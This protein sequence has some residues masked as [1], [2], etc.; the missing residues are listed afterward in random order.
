MYPLLYE[1]VNAT[2]LLFMKRFFFLLLLCSFFSC[3]KKENTHSLISSN[4][5]RNVT[6]LIQEVNQL[7]ALVASDAKLSTIQNQFLKARNSYKK[8]EWMSEYYY[9]TVSKSINGP[10]IPEFEENDGITVRSEEHT[11]DLQFL[12]LKKMMA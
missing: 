1:I 7:K 3:Q 4:F 9:P 2:T 6:E 10:A 12:S 8:L 5:T 11:S